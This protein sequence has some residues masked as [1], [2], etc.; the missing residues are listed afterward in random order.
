MSYRI[1]Y[2]LQ[3]LWVNTLEHAIILQHQYH[4][5]RLAS[6]THPRQYRKYGESCYK[7]SLQLLEMREDIQASALLQSPEK[8]AC[9]WCFAQR[10]NCYYGFPTAAHSCMLFAVSLAQFIAFLSSFMILLQRPNSKHVSHDETYPPHFLTSRIEHCLK[11]GCF[12]I[13]VSAFKSVL[14]PDDAASSS[15]G[16]QNHPMNGMTRH[17]K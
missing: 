13:Q 4:P 15:S 8:N 12:H 3:Q 6:S 9:D 5:I 16:H 11:R 7:R 2:W 1:L 14:Y 17:V 10:Y